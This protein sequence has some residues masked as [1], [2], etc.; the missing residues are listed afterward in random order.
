MPN[1]GKYSIYVHIPF[2]KARCSY[3]AFSSCTDLALQQRYFEKLFAEIEY[4]SDKSKAIG[5]VFL[6]GG[7]PSAVDLMYID[8]L[9]A[10]LNDC[11]NLSQVVE[12]TVECNPESATDEVLSCLK[13][14]GVNRLSF[15]LQSVNDTTLRTI[16]RLH[17]YKDFLAALDRA[18]RL[19]F[20]NVNADLIIGLPETHSDFLRTVNAVA[21]L[22]LRHVSLYALELHEG[23]SMFE[24][25]N[26]TPP[27]N[28]DE[29]ADM[30]DE[31]VEVLTSRGYKR[32]EI[33]NF[34]KAGFECKHNLNY[35]CEG[36]YYGFGA[37]AACFMDGERCVNPVNIDDYLCRSLQSMHSDRCDF[38]SL[39]DQ[40]NEFAMLGLRLERGVSISEFKER[41]G[42]DFF[43]FF[44]EA[45]NLVQKKC[46]IVE[47]DRVRVPADKFYVI[48]SILSDLCNFD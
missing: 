10:K 15:G 8:V 7:T 2:C 34:A 43:L 6:G 21:N 24:K 26:G 32:Y 31:A 48:N 28:D 44:D 5:T 9:F 37:S 42:A 1:Y 30:Y 17:S 13:R 47:G 33:S 16:G 40:A 29:M 18:S 46:L 22:P 41:Y 23:T 19:G 20:Y 35:W 25:L 38:V 36:V 45:N 27:F 3:C 12:T 14:N 11:F 4:Y 39:R